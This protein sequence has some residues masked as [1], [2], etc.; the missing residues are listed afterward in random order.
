M[1]HI[2]PI[3]N[4][5]NIILDIIIHDRGV[6]GN[7][8]HSICLLRVKIIINRN[9]SN[10]FHYGM[11][12]G[13]ARHNLSIFLCVT[14]ITTMFSEN[15]ETF[16]RLYHLFHTSVKTKQTTLVVFPVPWRSGILYNKFQLYFMSDLNY[17]GLSWWPVRKVGYKMKANGL[18]IGQSILG[19]RWVLSPILSWIDFMAHNWK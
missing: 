8:Q 14:T 3:P 11:Y 18:F 15:Y 13:C 4:L 6:I 9:S 1:F 12:K 7:C 19:S 5:L 16:E 2:C 17:L 10:P